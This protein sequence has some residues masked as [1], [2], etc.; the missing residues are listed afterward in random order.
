MSD[1]GHAITRTGTRRKTHISVSHPSPT[2]TLANRSR[3]VIACDGFLSSP[4][5]HWEQYGIFMGVASQDTIVQMD[6]AVRKFLGRKQFERNGPVLGLNQWYAGA[7]EDRNHMDAEL[8]DL[9]FVQKRSNDLATSH[10]PNIFTR[11]RAQSLH[12]W[13][14]RLSRKLE[15]LQQ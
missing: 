7:D 12:E 3:L 5:V 1:V 10:H 15:S 2:T 6:Y 14:N 4:I 8:V 13:L 9:S 11:L